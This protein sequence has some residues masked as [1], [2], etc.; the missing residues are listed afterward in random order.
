[1]Y[2][3]GLFIESNMTGPCPTALVSIDPK[4]LNTGHTY[5]QSI[6][7]VAGLIKVVDVQ[8][9]DHLESGIIEIAS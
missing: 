1:M 7:L 8:E 3:L 9:I 6:C 5:L 2:D 4:Q